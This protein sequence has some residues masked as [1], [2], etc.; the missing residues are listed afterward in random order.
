[1]PSS[2][3]FIRRRT[4]VRAALLVGSRAGLTYGVCIPVARDRRRSTDV[5]RNELCVDGEMFSNRTCVWDSRT[6][7]TKHN[8]VSTDESLRSRES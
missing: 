4:A 3:E 7:K 6:G 5:W 2:V 1:V 8:C